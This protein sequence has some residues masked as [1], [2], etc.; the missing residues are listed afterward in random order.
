MKKQLLK[1]NLFLV[2]FIIY[3]FVSR[4]FGA[5]YQV[6]LEQAIVIGQGRV[7]LLLYLQHNGIT[8]T[9]A[10]AL[11]PYY[12]IAELSYT[13]GNYRNFSVN[14]GGL[15]LSG[16]T[17]QG[18]ITATITDPSGANAKSVSCNIKCND[19]NGIIKGEYTGIC[20]GIP[21]LGGIEGKSMNKFS[22][23]GNYST[24]LF[25][26]F[27]YGPSFI[28]DEK[29]HSMNISLNYSGNS[30]TSAWA[31]Y[32]KASTSPYGSAITGTNFDEMLEYISANGSRSKAFILS[33]YDLTVT[34][35]SVTITGDTL[36]GDVSV[37]L[38]Y[39]VT[40]EGTYRYALKCKIIGRTLIG[41]YDVY[42]GVTLI[43]SNGYLAGHIGDS[44]FISMPAID[45]V[46]ATNYQPGSAFTPPYFSDLTQNQW[47]NKLK[48]AGI[49]MYNSPEIGFFHSD[50][51]LA[52][53]Q[54]T[55]NKQYDNRSETGYGGV[56]SM[57]TLNKVALDNN[58]AY[59]ALMS[60]QR[61]GYF[62]ISQGWGK[63]KLKEY[64]KGMFWESVFSGRA[65]MELY[66]ATGDKEWLDIAK[67][68][69]GV[70]K[71]LQTN[72]RTWA[73]G[74]WTYYDEE[75]DV[76]GHSN[77]RDDR[78]YDYRPLHCADFL[79]FLGS[80]RVD[81]RVSDF[82]QVEQDAYT[83]MKNNIDWVD[84]WK[85]RRPGSSIEAFGPTTFLLYML[86]Y[87]SSVD[88]THLNK[89]IQYVE[90]NLTNWEHTSGGSFAPAVTGYFPRHD[91]DDYPKA[92]VA[93]SSR[94][95]WAYLLMYKKTGNAVWLAKGKALAYSA[96]SRQNLS[97]GMLHHLG[98]NNL[99]VNDIA[100][101]TSYDQ[102]VYQSLKAESL[103]NLY[104]CYKL[105]IEFG[106]LQDEEVL[107]KF[108]A[109]VDSGMAP[110]AV[111]FDGSL[112][113]GLNKTYAWNFG[114]GTTGIGANINHTYLIA[115]TYKV[116]LTVTSN[117]IIDKAYKIIKVY[118]SPV[119]TYITVNPAGILL[120]P[121]HQQ[122]YSALALDQY[123]RALSSQP[124]FTWSVTGSNSVNTSG[125]LTAQATAGNHM[126]FMI[127][128]Q[129]GSVNGSAK[130]YV[131]D[132]IPK[133]GYRYLK[134]IADKG[135]T[136]QNAH[137]YDVKW[138]DNGVKWPPVYFTSSSVGD[139]NVS[140]WGDWTTPY[141]I[142]DN[143]GV[144]GE[145]R[146]S[147]STNT[148]DLS[149]VYTIIPDSIIIEFSTDPLRISKNVWLAASTNGQ[150][151][152][153]LYKQSW[154]AGVSKQTIILTGNHFTV[155]FY[156][157][158]GSNNPV[159]GVS[160]NISGYGTVLS[161]SSGYASRSL[162]D[163]NS[164]NYTAT[165]TNYYDTSGSF[166]LSGSDITENIVIIQAPVYP[167]T[168]IVKDD[169]ARA[170]QDA[171]ISINSSQ[172]Y[173][174]INGQAIISLM[175]GNYNYNVSK[176]GYFGATGT[177]IVSGS[178]VTENVT[179][180][181][182][183]SKMN[184][185]ITFNT[186]SD[187]LTTD[188][189]F[190]IT[191]TA[192]SGLPVTFMVISG[193]ATVIG[194]TVTLTGDTG[195][196]VIR[197]E[198]GGNANYYPAPPVEQSFK[199]NYPAFYC[200]ADADTT[201]GPEP[202]T[203]NFTG[204]AND[205]SIGSGAFEE[206]AGQV[207]ME[208]ENYSSSSQ[209]GDV[210]SWVI[211]NA[212]V[213]Y[214]GTGYITTA[215]AANGD[216][217]NGCDASYQINFSTAGT[218]YVWIRRYAVSG[219]YNSAHVGLDGTE[220]GTSFDN[221]TS[222]YNAWAWKKGGT[223]L[224]VTAGEHT[225]NL[226]RRE[227]DYRTDKIILTTNSTYTPTGE[228]PAE[229][230]RSSGTGCVYVWNFGD[231]DTSHQQNPQHI[232]T[233]SGN[234]KAVLTVTNGAK[235]STDTVYITVDQLVDEAKIYGKQKSITVYP[236]PTTG[237]LYINGLANGEV[238]AVYDLLGIKIS[239]TTVTINNTGFVNLTELPT[240]IYFLKINDK[241]IKIIRK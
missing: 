207:V 180:V 186:I 182:D 236:N 146:V 169:S 237:I 14:V 74:T 104:N 80:L 181:K 112:S 31:Q 33:E 75:N 119:L 18:T 58:L 40:N 34:S 35:Y 232:Y 136:G 191:A 11:A 123:E 71:D 2:V 185:T 117:G 64:Y 125:L 85:D 226:R 152:D 100:R 215:T 23:S 126:P 101:V 98:A 76:I 1:K 164:Y 77:E 72:M 220:A 60:A 137:M 151:W 21:T 239:E 3:G 103:H 170:V 8:F 211:T 234:Y 111:N 20:N 22:P 110:L 87:A 38:M 159:E 212:T 229:S 122:Q 227:P 231:G 13:W 56:V 205:C 115:G 221:L 55:G 90:N 42:D 153:T 51:A 45:T 39:N 32:S 57:I 224:S 48:A 193:P 70:L 121:A 17:I 97:T 49:W 167:V 67:Q 241:T 113:M 223:T 78:S 6:V 15:T 114:D 138:Y 62:L 127:T 175:N 174:D 4:V 171:M 96:L 129:N 10:K 124:S 196:V 95:A 84:L 46:T 88:T 202:L 134:V 116:E 150:I 155:N 93:A 147:P 142:Y 41:S 176:T 89:V 16:N 214:S 79:Y 195:T 208:A 92:S 132:S 26:E 73:N 118:N 165:K 194:N 168:F 52:S 228:G 99:S 140:M 43:K 139:M 238:I 206:S 184:Q 213:G 12:S 66:N 37:Q 24:T 61:A 201:Y 222:D 36:Y 135:P 94:M 158:D 144:G 133:Y 183:T 192:S 203:V 173:T 200:I 108:T 217:T 148:L 86:K 154:P 178:P 63:Y 235:Q 225:F 131:V 143:T 30:V 44:S 130:F 83:W 128:A 53:V 156:V 54:G 163:S 27:P 209:N 166:I 7:P 9:S 145:I 82:A 216:W 65:Y 141:K 230:P 120:L 219:S 233:S 204:W 91:I 218:Y 107:A 105:L 160:I 197:A 240:G 68:Y 162:P 190:T 172:Y 28:E 50:I 29:H 106:Q 210:V 81:G 187:K 199:V 69:A 25:L 19:N 47:L 109:D 189:P 157:K 188:A 198:Q 179:I 177:V 161:N 5:E 102:H 149:P 59:N